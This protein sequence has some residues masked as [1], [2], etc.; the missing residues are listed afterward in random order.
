M[1]ASQQHGLEIEKII[2]EEFKRRSRSALPS[3]MPLEQSHTA[4]FDVPG[5]VDPYQRGIPTSIKAAKIKAAN[6]T[7]YLADANRI[8]DLINFKETRLLVS[9]YY[10]K[11]SYKVFNEI[12]EYIITGEEWE[13][14]MG[15]IPLD[16]IHSF[17]KAIKCPNAD[18]AKKI[19]KNWK[20][21]LSQLFPDTMIKWNAKIG[22]SGQRRLQCSVDLRDVEDVIQDKKR[23]KVF[24]SPKDP[25]GV[26]RPAYLRSVS[27]HLWY[28]G[29]RLPFPIFSEPRVR[30]KKEA[31]VSEEN[32]NP[33][34]LT[35]KNAPIS[36][37][38]MSPR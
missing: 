13:T 2:K 5:Y 21:E 26:V 30:N 28:D 31:N 17:S 6:A 1:S 9:L 27:N 4:R 16:V 10:Q 29:M 3:S 19:V 34:V 24:G 25:K 33:L 20:E 11:G 36:R 32:Q 7:V 23:I 22:S 37:K 14:L 8:S 12:R 15:G 38:P 35:P 18:E